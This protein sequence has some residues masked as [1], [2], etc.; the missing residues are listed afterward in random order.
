[1]HVAVVSGTLDP[2]STPDRPDWSG[3]ARHLREVVDTLALDGHRVEAVVPGRPSSATPGTAVVHRAPLG[4][5]E[6]GPG[7]AV[8]ALAD[9]LRALWPDRVPDVVYA[10]H[11]T[12]AL[13]AWQ[14]GA[15]AAS[16]VVQLVHAGELE[17]DGDR[18]AVERAVLHRADLVVVTSRADRDALLTVGIAPDRLQVVPVT[19]DA[20]EFHPDGPVLRRGDRRR[21]LALGGVDAEGGA[22]PAVRALAGVPGAEL[23]VAGGRPGE[24]DDPDRARLFA[25]ARGHGVDDRVRFLGPVDRREVPRL[26]RSADAVVSAAPRWCTGFSA[27]EAMACGRAVVATAVGG[28]ADI[29]VDQVCGR[30]VPPGDDRALAR[31]LHEVLAQEGRWMA[32]GVAGRNRVEAAY[33]RG[34]PARALTDVFEQVRAAGTHAV[35]G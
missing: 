17:P 6:A 26:L 22:G 19:V 4:A 24:E 35:A 15:G 27:L 1:M 5:R 33:R 29:V 10:H 32:F 25:L 9:R 31:A 28:N 11:W 8:H 34:G 7:P 23:L 2:W 20:E 18:A 12:A 16:P 13:A 3:R 30:T 14:A 21:L